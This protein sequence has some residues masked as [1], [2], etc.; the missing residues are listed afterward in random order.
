MAKRAALLLAVAGLVAVALL[1]GRIALLL[2]A[3]VVAIAAAGEMFRLLRARGAL[4]SA[5][6]GYAGII[7]LLIV[8]YVRGERAPGLFPVVI[9]A[10]LGL[11]F[12]VMLMRL[13]RVNVTRAVAFTLLPVVTVGMLGAYVIA[14]RSARNGFRLAWVFAL[15][16]VGAELGAV[17]ITWIFR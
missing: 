4:P 16:A 7:A 9:A 3:I 13:D 12:A 10:T 2:T 15:M 14:L 17:S 1:A 8:A 11:A 6:L 5:P